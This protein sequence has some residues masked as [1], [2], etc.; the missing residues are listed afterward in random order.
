MEAVNTMLAEIDSDEIPT[1]LVM[2]KIDMLDDFV[3]RINRNDESLPILVWL[4][5]SS[6]EGISLLYQVLMERL[7]GEIAH[8]ELRLPPK[9]GRFRSCFTSFRQFIKRV[10]RERWQY[11]RGS[12]TYD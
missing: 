11:W 3:L 12:G 5:A 6:G 1:L 2:N 4:S 7:S 10:E 8:Y 9:A